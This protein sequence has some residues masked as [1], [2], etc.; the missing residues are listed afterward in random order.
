MLFVIY[1]CFIVLLTMMFCPS[2]VICA[3]CY[4]VMATIL[5]SIKDHVVDTP[6][7]K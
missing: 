5:L 2:V 7:S 3:I 4:V 6:P 1:A